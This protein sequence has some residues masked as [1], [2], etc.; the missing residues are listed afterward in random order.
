MG[1]NNSMSKMTVPM[2]REQK[3]VVIGTYTQFTVFQ[4]KK[5]I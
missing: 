5:K 4:E 2:Q 1:Q 3:L